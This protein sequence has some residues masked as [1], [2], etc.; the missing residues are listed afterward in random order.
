MLKNLTK[1]VLAVVC[2]FG[3]NMA[4]AQ[5]TTSTLSG[6]VTDDQGEGLPGANVQAIHTPTGSS[7]GI[8]TRTDGRFTLP[9]LRVGGPYVVTVSF[10]G[11]T[12]QKLEDIYLTLGQAFNTDF[13][14]KP[15]LS[16]L[17]EIVIT[18]ETS[19]FNRDRSGAETNINN[20]TLV[21]LPTITRSASDIYRLTP[22]ASGNSFGGRNDQY[23]N[24]SLD[25]SI[26][27]NPFGLD[28]ATPGGQTDAQPISLDAID[29]IQVALSPYDVTQSGF[30]GAAIN[31]VTKSGT[32]E[33]H[34][35]AFGFYRN[36]G[37]TGSKVAGDDIVVPDLSQY[38]TGFSIGGPII[39]NKVFFFAN[40]EI[41]RREDL[42]SNFLPNRGQAGS[43]VSRVLASDLDA[44]GAAL[45]SIG[46]EP[47]AYEGYTHRSD[48][49][50]GIFKLD[51]TLSQNHSVTAT[52]NFLNASKDKPAHPFAIGR[53]G[54]DLTT[55][56]FENSG[57]TINNVL[58]SGIVEVKSLFGN[59]FSNKFQAGFSSFRDTRDPKSTPI[60][61][62]NI[63][64]DGIRYIIAGHEPFSINNR[65]N[66]DVL[67]FTNN[68][69]IYSGDHTFTLGVSFEKFNFDNSFNL[70]S[71]GA[72][73][74]PAGTFG[75]FADVASFEAY[76]AAGS[77]TTLINDAETEFA[78][79][80]NA[81]TWALAE[82]NVGQAAFYAQDKW[83]VNSNL[84]VT[85]GIRFD[86][87]LYFNTP[88][89][90]QENIDRAGGAYDPTIIYTD[91]N[92][93]D[94]QFDHTKLPDGNVMISPRI[95]F[96]YDASG[97]NTMQ[98]RG[99]TGLFTGRFPFVWVGN[100]IA[101][102]N[103]FFYNVTHP[104]FQFPQ[105]WRTNI[106][107]DKK[108]GE[109]WVATADF[110]YTKDINGMMVRN[111]G[112]KSPTATLQG[113]DNRPIYDQVNDRVQV[114][115]SPTNAYVFTNTD[116]GRSI[117]ATLELKR[118][119]SNGLYTTLA[120][121]Y[122][123]S[124]DASSIEAEISS[125]AYERNPSFGNT[126]QA[127]LAPSIYGNKHRVLGTASKT[128]EYGNA[129]TTFSLVY[130]Y[131]QGGR[132]SYTY[133]GDINGDA[134]GLNDLIYIPLN[135]EIDQ[136]T[137]TGATDAQG[138]K[139]FIAQDEYLSERRGEYA[140]KYGVL[141]PWYSTWDLRILQDFQ[142]SETNKIQISLDIL[143]LGNL[144]NSD[145]GVR[146]FPQNTQ[147]IGVSVAAGTPTYSF[148]SA[149]QESFGNDF[150]LL[151]RWQMQVGLRY[152]F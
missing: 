73:A 122:L 43:N 152:I 103:F 80:N 101:N 107:V 14:M 83:E 85:A 32:N 126:N 113:V 79:N 138:L 13:E 88:E 106:G 102:P 133:S 98:I 148:D 118:N 137:F 131:A 124:K 147:P 54:P 38:Q 44:V 29:Q 86:K 7:Y 23:N 150:G 48:N 136:M 110:I 61:A 112:L 3:V 20:E 5:V 111:Y 140:E 75:G 40:M 117:N 33:F 28:A 16:Q 92:N 71:Y 69:D 99:G 72:F 39:K 76:V 125:D 30:T 115:G 109:G 90:A 47:G 143:N 128:I 53:R 70:T 139:D 49:E 9:N 120:Y 11:F 127:A 36:Q 84:T 121:N 130:E 119:W 116:V 74:G 21:K 51:I 41:D 87:A 66:Q 58:H 18:A 35:T 104:D 15:E 68:F 56:Q 62:L 135:S 95:G 42:G 134:S 82:T 8:S 132:F 149:L 22:S 114:F 105:V 89:L 17:G 59:K 77:L 67:Q 52:Y 6:K 91:E 94:I 27:N 141:S 129:A 37:L 100:Q 2:A 12:D 26:F 45:R 50:K 46:Y 78:T 96:N 108:F 123:D 1:I 63:N 144:V 55:L 4:S 142:V 145:W 10:V 151:S 34:G 57:Y 25:G 64:K 24:F 31:A 93:A 97:N 81:D 146:Q 19:D 65:L 60:P